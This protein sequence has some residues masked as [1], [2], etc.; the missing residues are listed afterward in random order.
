MPRYTQADRP[1]RVDTVL[2]EDVLLLQAFSGRESMSEPYHFTV[3]LLSEDPA[4]AAADLLRS[5]MLLTLFTP[6]GEP[7]FIHGLVKSFTELHRREDFT[8]YRAELVPWTWFLSLTRGCRIFQEMDVLDIVEQV[9]GDLGFSDY[10]IRCTRSYEEREYC[11]QY[12]ESC[13]SFVHRLLEEEGI[14]YFF[15]HGESAHTMVITDANTSFQPC[16]HQQSARMA[17]E[18]T[19]NEDVVTAVERQHAVHEGAVTLSDYDP[20]Q[21]RL[22]LM[23]M[24]LTEEGE[25]IYDYPG[26]FTDLDR[27]ERYAVLQLEERELQALV[28]KGESTCR[29]FTTGFRF[30]L[31][32]HHRSD[33]NAEYVLTSVRHSAIAGDY[34]SWETAELDYTNEFT[35]IP[36]DVPY[37]PPRKTP[38]PRIRGTQTALVV[39][40]SGEEIYVDRYGRI[41][42]Q[43]HWDREGQ[44]D[45]NSSCWIRV[46]TPWAGK[47][48]GTISIPRIGNEVV[49]GF[50]EGDP[51]RPLVV[52]SVYN[53]EQ[54]PPFGLPDA[55]IQMGMKSRSSPGGGGHN[56]ITMTDT[57]GEE[58]MNIH[59]QY[60]MATTVGND[61]TQN[62]MNNRTAS[63]AV[64]ETMDVGSNQTLSVASNQDTS[65]GADQSLSVG[66]GQTITVGG[67][68]ALSVAG[69]NTVDVGA[70]HGVTAGANVA[71][72]SGADTS[73]DAGANVAV[74][75]SANADISAGAQI[76]VSAGASI[77]LSAGGSSIEI[78]PGGVT[79]SSGGMITVQGAMIKHNA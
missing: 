75:A 56:E 47:G 48:W 44:K 42:V 22:N 10:E 1:L 51:D 34:R 77:T 17:G 20:L 72:S 79:I 25:E 63:V 5:P 60:D 16:P 36:H 54:V 30:E 37:R 32:G 40:P 66:G 73:V 59:A 27:A 11:V 53:A 28:L 45:E 38:R 13:L 52:G 4:V 8:H 35:A 14:F 9:F 43:F 33:T 3:E 12:R 29:A 19:P 64:D 23:H 46:A 65:V 49:V 70:D 69:G 68:R 50:E 18:A 24:A 55:G 31:R 57:A 21:P 2:D 15:E 78:G 67:D 58:M 39:G 26:G 61:Q 74:A 71:M 62:V 7:R 6:T 76:S 41:K